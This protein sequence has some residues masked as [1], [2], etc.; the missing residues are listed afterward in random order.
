[1]VN[2]TIIRDIILFCYNSQSFDILIC[3]IKENAFLYNIY[4]VVISLLHK[5]VLEI[6]E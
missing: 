4:C 6:T 5:H 2:F 3:G 1:M